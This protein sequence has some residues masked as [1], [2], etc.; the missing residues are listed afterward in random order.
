MKNFV[1]AIGFRNGQGNRLKPKL[2]NLFDA[3]RKRMEDLE[4]MHRWY[5]S[6]RRK[7]FAM[8]WGEQRIRERIQDTLKTPEYHVRQ[9]QRK[10]ER[11]RVRIVE[12]FL[13]RF[14]DRVRDVFDPRQLQLEPIRK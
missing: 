2:L 12:R 8:K 7:D 6:K 1:K 11:E 10:E 13:E 5:R 3:F 9:L 4:L 14:R